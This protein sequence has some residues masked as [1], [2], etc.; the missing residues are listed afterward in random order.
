MPTVV[1]TFEGLFKKSQP[2]YVHL[3][4]CRVG[5]LGLTFSFVDFSCS[6]DLLATRPVWHSSGKYFVVPNKA[7]EILVIQV[8]G[9]K[10]IGTFSNGGHDSEVAELA[11]SSNGKYLAS[12]GVDGKILVWEISSKS[13]IS[14]YQ[15]TESSPITSLA[16]S[17]K[18]NLLA[19]ADAK[20]T[21]SRWSDP[22]PSSFLHPAES[23]PGAPR[24]RARSP[25]FG[26][27]ELDVEDEEL[28]QHRQKSTSISPVKARKSKRGA[29]DEDEGDD[30]AMADVDGEDDDEDHGEEYGDDWII[31]DDGEHAKAKAEELGKR[32]RG[33]R[34]GGG[35]REVVSVAESQPPFQ[36]GS[37]AWKSKKRYMSK[38]LLPLLHFLARR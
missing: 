28:I 26:D 30:T 27:D 9:W 36:P 37:T 25:L 23:G 3:S 35:V 32:S 13:V 6:S 17:P 19:F 22:V 11:F 33:G 15:T 5:V 12:S 21:F 7:H 8:D 34:T 1:K 38:S 31:D 14:T 4:V 16:F 10:K 2:E 20:G 29:E 24:K 18:S